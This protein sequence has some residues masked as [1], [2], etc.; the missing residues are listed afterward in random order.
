[1]VRN[2][3]KTRV[4]FIIPS[5]DPGGIENYL[6]RFLNFSKLEIEAI[7]LV[8]NKEKG[9][10]HAQFELATNELHY[11]SLGYIS[12][13]K[14]VWFGRFLKQVKVD[15]ILDF[16]ANFAGATMLVSKLVGTPKRITFYRQGKNHFKPNFIRNIVNHI[17]NKLVD[18]FATNIL[19]N[20]F[21]ALDFFYPNRG[22]DLRFKVIYNGIELEEFRKLN[23]TRELR[24]KYGLDPD[25]FIIG[26]AGRKDPVK[27][28]QL[29]FDIA[30]SSQ[31]DC[32][33][34]FVLVG[35]N[36]DK[37]SFLLENKH[38]NIVSLGFQSN[39][40][41][42]LNCFDLFVFPS[43]SEGQPNALIEAIAVGLPVI[44]SDIPS[45]KECLP[46]SHHKYLANPHDINKFKALLFKA[47][48]NELPR[49]VDETFIESNFR[50][51]HNFN[52]LLKE[53]C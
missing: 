9:L 30:T 16:N 31:F 5:T 14:L 46:Y 10:L 41:E 49:I 27:N 35:E 38:N 52:M 51:N 34:L 45:I 13:L 42:V 44:A 12:P 40:V 47:L 23:H 37:Y 29:L 7:V 20:S 18:A 21:A 36:T 26:H 43:F 8:R 32:K 19:S 6:L 39:M 17:L 25:A 3:T 50:A 24:L 33:V 22:A 48:S 53:I 1:M 28:V 2:L 11:K 15:V 4:L